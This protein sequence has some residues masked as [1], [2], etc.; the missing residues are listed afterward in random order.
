[1][2]KSKQTRAPATRLSPQRAG[3]A[4][5]VSRR[6]ARPRGAPATVDEYFARVPEPARGMLAK[7]RTAIRSAVPRDAMETISYRIPA[8]TRNGVLVWYAAFSDHVSLFPGGSVLGRF[9]DDTAGLKMSKGTIQFPLDKP[10]PLALIKR[11]VSARV[12]E[13]EAGRR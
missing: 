8:F 12:A 13:R 7:M 5:R 1:L 9:K 11:I 3:T 4:K 10:L 2:A 6:T